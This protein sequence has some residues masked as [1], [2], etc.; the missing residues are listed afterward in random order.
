MPPPS[1]NTIINYV[2]CAL[3]FIEIM[4]LI[5]ATSSYYEVPV[6]VWTATLSILKY[7]AT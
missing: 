7:I 2:Q 6:I 4:S 1:Q 3:K 5:V